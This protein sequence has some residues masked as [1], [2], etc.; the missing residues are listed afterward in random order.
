MSCQ[1]LLQALAIVATTAMLAGAAETKRSKGNRI[2]KQK[3]YC[4]SCSTRHS[5]LVRE[6]VSMCCFD[7]C[8]VLNVEHGRLE[9]RAERGKTCR[10][11]ASLDPLDAAGIRLKP[12]QPLPQAVLLLSQVPSRLCMENVTVPASTGLVWSCTHGAWRPLSVRNR[13]HALL[14]ASSIPGLTSWPACGTEPQHLASLNLEAVYTSLIGL[15]TRTA[16]AS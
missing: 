9:H 7:L 11:L 2:T 8:E 4:C 6:R 13:A 12:L 3:M 15:V 16:E 5:Q 1:A 14:F 10:A